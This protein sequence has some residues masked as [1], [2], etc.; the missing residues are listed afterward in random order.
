VTATLVCA[1]VVP[2]ARA[3][4]PAGA[5]TT[6]GAWHFA[7]APALHPPKLLVQDRSKTVPTGDFLATAMPNVADARPMT[8]EGGPLILDGRLRPVWVRGVG[9]RLIAS[10]LQQESYQGQPV[11]V[12]WE[13]APNRLAS[14]FTDARVVVVDRH[15]RQIAVLRSSP[16]WT[17][18]AHDAWIDGNDIWVTVGRFVAGQ[19][20]TPYGGRPGSK[21]WDMGAQEYDL[22]TGRVVYT[23]DA[24]NPMG[25]PHVSLADSEVAPPTTP[26][27]AWDA[28]HLNSIQ[29][30]PDRRLLISMRNT[31]AIY[32]VDP[33]SGRTVWTLGGKHSSFASG[34]GTHFAWQHDA[35]LVTTG[36]DDGT[37]SREKLTVYNDNCCPSG[38]LGR[39]LGPSEGLVLRLDTVAWRASLAAAYRHNPPLHT[40]YLGSMELEPDGDAL[41]GSGSSFSEYTPA[42]KDLFDATWPGKDESY[43]VLGT[44]TWVGTPYYPPSGVLRRVGGRG[45]VY[46][47]W[48]GATQVARWEVLG[49]A[50]ASQLRGVASRPRVGFETAIP[51]ARTYR[52]YQVRALDA[53]GHMLGASRSFSG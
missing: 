3:S 19:D 22:R 20:L 7:S 36:S 46:A 34:P 37:G 45:V 31:W 47:S 6:A 4:D 38:M 26:G 18:D 15:Y 10:N 8:G 9:S 5:Y 29:I 51:L 12:W 23:W 39:A 40:P 43:R 48:N 53:Q 42:G 49:G 41:V 17:I 44:T 14:R 35:R 32:L 13:A 27:T 33:Q 50:S 11:L 25:Q 52:T 21:V 16:P 24:L 1:A 2:A 30:L 28:Y